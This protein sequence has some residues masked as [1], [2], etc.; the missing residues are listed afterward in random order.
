MGQVDKLMDVS[1]HM[2]K[3]GLVEEASELR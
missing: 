1:M 2:E 3:L